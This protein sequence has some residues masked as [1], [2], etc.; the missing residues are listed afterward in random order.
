MNLGCRIHI[1][2]QLPELVSKRS[3]HSGSQ[4]LNEVIIRDETKWLNLGVVGNKNSIKIE[5]SF[6][7]DTFPVPLNFH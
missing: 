5:F 4:Q 7:V 3:I 6:D 2:R 1:E